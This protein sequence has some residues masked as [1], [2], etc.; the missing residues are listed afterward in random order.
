MKDIPATT[1]LPCEEREYVSGQIPP[2]HSMEDFDDDSF[3]GRD[4]F[5]S[6]FAYRIAAMRNLGRVLQSR[7]IVMPDGPIVDRVDAYLVNWRL[8]LPDNKKDFINAEGQLDEM[9]FQAH[10]ITEATT[11]LLHREL[12]ELDSSVARNVTSC[13][14]HKPIAAGPTYNIH[15]AKTIQAA[16]EVSKL[17]QLPV[18][19]VKHSHFFTCVVTLASIVHLSCWSALM[20]LIHDEDLKQQLRLNTGALKTLSQVWPAAGKAFGQVKGVAQE[21]YAGKKQAAE[22][23]YWAELSDEEIMRSII[24]D[25]TIMEELQM[26]N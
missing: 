12:S 20:P 22:L 10:M 23:G 18:P 15:A 8:H 13:A 9:L 25:Q 7:A 19:L 4:F 2:P 21:I 26:L 24:E 6:S 1:L 14:P 16:Q 3:D 11:I 5:Y 17:I